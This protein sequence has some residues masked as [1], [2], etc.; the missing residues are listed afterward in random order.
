MGKFNDIN[1]KQWKEYNHIRT[2]SLWIIDK[3]NL[4]DKDFMGAFI[5][6]IPEQLIER[7]TKK[8]DLILDFFIGSGT[9]AYVSKKMERKLIGVDIDN[10]QI[11]KLRE[12]YKDNTN[13]Y[14]PTFVWGDST[15]RDTNSAISFWVKNKSEK[16]KVQFII[17]HPPYWNAIKFTDNPFD[18]SNCKS[19]DEFISSFKTLVTYCSE[20]IEEN[21]FVALIIGDVYIKRELVPLSWICMNIF[22][23]RKFLL[24]S[25]IV[26]NISGNEKSK[27]KNNNLWRYR[28]LNGNFN[29]FK[30][31][32]IF[33]L[34]KT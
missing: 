7:Y 27:G 22:R 8:D 24:K 10:K 14:E 20:Y 5:P 26:K 23:K 9:S 18:F 25:T 17:L 19:L 12:L 13:L 1:I 3:G 32:Y 33:I 11:N 21:R 31:E 6:E 30:H 2:D 29:V 28:A 16:E 15:T 4:Y 34:Q